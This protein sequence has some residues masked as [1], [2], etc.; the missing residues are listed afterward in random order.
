MRPEQRGRSV[1]N[2]R[3][4]SPIRSPKGNDR[5]IGRCVRSLTDHSPIRRS[6][7]CHALRFV[8]QGAWLS[9]FSPVSGRP[10]RSLPIIDRSSTDHVKRPI[11]PLTPDRTKSA[12]ETGA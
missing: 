11:T 8:A 10:P 1:P 12:A 5:L 4:R 7:R 6:N 3:D 2:F 9:G